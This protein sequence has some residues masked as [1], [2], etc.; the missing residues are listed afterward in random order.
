MSWLVVGV[1]V[2]FVSFYIIAGF[3][4][5]LDKLA[6]DICQGFIDFAGRKS[7]YCRARIPEE[8]LPGTD[9]LPSSKSQL[10]KLSNYTPK[11]QYHRPI[12]TYTYDSVSDALFSDIVKIT[13]QNI[14][15]SQ[16]NEI[17]SKT[18]LTPPFKKIFNILTKEPHYPGIQP[19]RM[20][21]IPKP[22]AITRWE[23]EFDNP[24]F[25][26]PYWPNNLS[27]LNVYVDRVYQ[28]E[29]SRV[30]VAKKKKAILLERQACH[31]QRVEELSSKAHAAYEKACEIQEKAFIFQTSEFTRD[32]E[33]YSRAFNADKN[34][35]QEIYNE[36]I[37]PGK[38][39]LLARISL[40][41][42]TTNL[43]SFVSREHQTSFDEESG[44]LIHEHRFPD[45]AAFE[46]MKF[47]ELKAGPTP[48]PA[49][50]KEAKEAAKKLYPSLCLRFAAEI[51]LLDEENIVEAITI[52]GWADYIEQAT[53]QQKRAYCASMFATM[54]QVKSLNISALDPVVAFNTLKGIAAQSLEFTPI[55]PIVRLDTNDSRFIDP[56]EVLSKMKNGENLATM[57]WGDF[58][59]LCRELFERAFA[60]SGAEVKVTQASRDQ[61]I[62]AIIF[63]PD[64]LRGGKIVIQAKRYTNTVDVSAVRDLYGSVMNEGANK[65][66]LVTTSQYGPDAYSFAKDKPI[67]LLNG[68]ELLG[69]LEK[70]GY[71]FRIDLAEAKSLL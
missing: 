56:K 70:N 61:G 33:R 65:G 3:I 39:G 41:L 17:L 37:E 21:P 7:L 31:N 42:K 16:L 45:I 69:L 44:V 66:I 58:E 22:P 62:D 59:H 63:D 30:D 35:I 8:L 60:E 27:L 9:P 50:K 55:A 24:V 64:P 67:T 68:N 49:N 40:A 23:F 46:W 29:K 14:F 6:S 51:A 47:V 38:K 48:R 2:L 1:I 34:K 4:N 28:S 36:T 52:N 54:K 10:D 71:K 20:L 18:P 19:Q 26:P 5:V 32:K 25:D 15:L 43:P 53:G 12:K 57:D 11:Q 13:N